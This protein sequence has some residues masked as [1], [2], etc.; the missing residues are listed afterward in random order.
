M[1]VIEATDDVGAIECFGLLR[2][3]SAPGGTT[4]LCIN[5]ICQEEGVSI[6]SS[7][8]RNISGSVS[9]AEIMPFV[10]EGNCCRKSRHDDQRVYCHPGF[11]INWL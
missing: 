11:H 7:D 1:I 6:N 2:T 10:P 9:E 5:T 4:N 8:P 3:H